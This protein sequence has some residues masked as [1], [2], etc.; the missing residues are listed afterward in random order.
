VVARF[1]PGPSGNTD[2]RMAVR[3]H[4]A[5]LP[6]VVELAGTIDTA[7]A[8]YL[9]ALLGL[10][11]GD[12]IVDLTRVTFLNCEGLTQLLRLH[13]HLITNGATLRLTGARPDTSR[14]IAITDLHKLSPF[15]P[16]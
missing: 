15:Q 9:H 11:P 16:G 7:T 3:V 10:P 13:T 8:P 1:S 5:T 6:T 14:L 2:R 12:V 4:C